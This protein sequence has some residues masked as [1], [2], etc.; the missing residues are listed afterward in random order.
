MSILK[1]HRNVELGYLQICDGILGNTA[2]VCGIN[3]FNRQKGIR[4]ITI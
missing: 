2:I 3:G 1:V 4:M